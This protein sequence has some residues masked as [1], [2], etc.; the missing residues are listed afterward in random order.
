LRIRPCLHN[1]PLY[2]VWLS[3][4]ITARV[5]LFF[6]AVHGE[7]S[8]VLLHFIFWWVRRKGFRHECSLGPFICT[9]GKCVVR[10]TFRWTSGKTGIRPNLPSD[11]YIRLYKWSKYFIAASARRA[12]MRHAYATKSKNV[13]SEFHAKQ[14]RKK[15]TY[16]KNGLW[17]YRLV[18]PPFFRS[19]RYRRSSTTLQTHYFCFLFFI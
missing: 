15:H 9:E 17:T 4:P 10:K 5:Y 11:S 18:I 8:S 7:G 3:I 2:L 16:R 6:L 14:W 19:K 13:S 12:A 1:A